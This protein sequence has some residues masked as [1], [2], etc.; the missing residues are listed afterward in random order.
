MSI[1]SLP[2]AKFKYPRPGDEQLRLRHQKQVAALTAELH[3]S[4]ARERASQ[5]AN[6]ALLFTA[7]KYL[8]A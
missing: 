5:Q 7:S 1:L 6:A 8:G 4:L 3:A 2:G